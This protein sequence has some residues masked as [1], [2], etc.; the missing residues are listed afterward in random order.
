MKYIF[1][2]III[3]MPGC[4]SDRYLTAEEDAQLRQKCAEDCAI[5]PMKLW[6]QIEQLI[7]SLTI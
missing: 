2:F 3:L 1:A 4:A 6:R 5:V 7:K